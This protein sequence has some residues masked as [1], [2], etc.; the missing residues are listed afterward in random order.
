VNCA[1]RLEINQSELTIVAMVEAGW[2]GR[3]NDY[4]CN[5]AFQNYIFKTKR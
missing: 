2:F 5:H 1:R 4:V 3:T